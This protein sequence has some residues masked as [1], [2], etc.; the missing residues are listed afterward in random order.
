MSVFYDLIS[1]DEVPA[2]HVIEVAGYPQDEAGSL[3]AFQYRQS[4]APDLFLGV[5]LPSNSGR[6]LIG[7]VCSTLSPS[8]SLTHESM[9]THVP[10][11]A[12]VCLHSVCVAPAH[13]RRG[14]ALGLLREYGARLQTAAYEGAG[15]ERILL[16]AHE[17]LRGLYEKAGFEW[18][19]LS[20]V[21]HGSQPWFEMRRALASQLP[22]PPPPAA[23][24]A[25]LWAALQR[26][27]SR[28][29]PMAQLLPSFANGV[30]DLAADLDGSRT[31]KYD[32]LCPRQ[33][34]GSVILKSGVATVVERESVR[35]EPE[36]QPSS[37]LEALPAPSTL[38]PWWRVTPDAMAF[39]NIGFSRPVQSQI[40]S[41]KRIK[42]LLCAECDLGP[43][44]WHEEGG[45]EFWL[46][47]SRVG[48]CV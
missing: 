34:C 17:E 10:G 35:L 33:G 41:D 26:A 30:H 29:K 2:A 4:Q 47:C 3:A 32:L 22:G 8:P 31:N 38:M 39:E 48:Y 18:V 27:S 45:N 21:V 20:P 13:R 28:P 7:F 37:I 14:L 36:D 40:Q 23:A 19:G 24:P 44:G 6:T 42:L 9:A 11:G 15:Y 5:F 25:D 16:I 43:L 12:S 46:A 1:S